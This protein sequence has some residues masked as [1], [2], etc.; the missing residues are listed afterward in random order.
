[1]IDMASRGLEFFMLPSEFVPLVEDL[2]AR[3][4]V[5]AVVI[6]HPP[7]LPRLVAPRERIAPL[8]TAVPPR[9]ICLSA[10]RAA[11]ERDDPRRVPLA[12]LGCVSCDFPQLSGEVL[13]KAQLGAKSDWYDL[14]TRTA[15]E[16]PAVIRLFERVVPQFRRMLARPV[17]VINTI[18]GAQGPRS[19]VGYSLGAANWAARGGELRARGVQNVSYEIRSPEP[20]ARN[21]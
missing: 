4:D 16:N 3:L 9:A 15:H 8:V 5:W 7:A 17:W 19:S 6:W 13:Y 1:M 18:T 14:A 21:E 12:K 10:D 20:G 11:L 2:M